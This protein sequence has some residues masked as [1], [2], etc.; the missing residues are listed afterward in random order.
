MYMGQRVTSAST[1]YLERSTKASDQY[2]YPSGGA[3]ISAD[4]ARRIVV[5]T[6]SIAPSIAVRCRFQQIRTLARINGQVDVSLNIGGLY[7]LNDKQEIGS[8]SGLSRFGIARFGVN[9][10]ASEAV[11]MFKQPFLIDMNGYYAFLTMEQ[12]SDDL[13]FQIIKTLLEYE[14]ESGRMT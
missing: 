7:G 6:R 10:F 4:T 1:I 14:P 13:T 11:Q 2:M 3:F 12:T 9:R 8:G 5:R